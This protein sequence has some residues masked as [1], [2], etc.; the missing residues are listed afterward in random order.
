MPPFNN[1]M[2]DRNLAFVNGTS[3]PNLPSHPE[4]PTKENEHRFEHPLR[5]VLP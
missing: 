1:A 4:I 2:L 5:R 3:V